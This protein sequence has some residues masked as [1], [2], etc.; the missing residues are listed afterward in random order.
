ML[1]RR[2]YRNGWR[3]LLRDPQLR[4]LAAACVVFAI[5][6]GAC[7]LLVDGRTWAD[8]LRHAPLTALTA[9]TTAGFSTIP[10]DELDA[11]SKL[12]LVF[13]MLLGGGVGSTAGGMKVLR[14]V[15]LIRMVQVVLMRSSLSPHAVLEPRVA[16]RRLH[17]PEIHTALMVMSCFVVV[18]MVSWL[19][20]VAHGYEAID[21]LFEVASATGTVG[22]SVGITRPD[23]EPL[24][25]AVLCVDM[26]LGRLEILALLVL[27][28][29]RTWFGKRAK[30]E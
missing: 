26:L 1:Y 24:L 11:A 8:V 20:F 13:S 21:A 15:I 4:M 3:D 10:P 5:L 27:I 22:L 30:L 29:P 12:L 6:L 16:G 17:A 7:M 23:L 28:Y 18:T 9:Q 14:L 25:K 2:A 19:L